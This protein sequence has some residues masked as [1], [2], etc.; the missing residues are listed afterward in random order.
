MSYLL[1][2]KLPSCF[3]ERKLLLELEQ[4]IGRKLSEFIPPKNDILIKKYDFTVFDSSGVEVLKSVEDFHRT[5]FPDDTQ[6]LKIRGSAWK[7]SESN[8][9]I[10]IEFGLTNN[11]TNLQISYEGNSAREVATGISAEVIS[12]LN[13]YKTNNYL[14]QWFGAVLSGFLTAIIIH[15]LAFA[16]RIHF[17]YYPIIV[18]GFAAVCGGLLGMF[19]V[20]KYKPYSTFETRL[21]EKRKKQLSWIVLGFI[22]FILFTVVGVYIRIKLLGF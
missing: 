21:N 17:A 13:S 19:F 9:D 20:T 6:L 4:Y 18:G 5:Y 22:G 8:L 11:A 2:K 7:N 1:T 14:F 16:L 12:I 15:L 10:R 3:I